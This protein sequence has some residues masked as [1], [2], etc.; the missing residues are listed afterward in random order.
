LGYHFQ[1]VRNRHAGFAG[2]CILSSRVDLMLQLEL[3]HDSD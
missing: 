1:Q 3:I 2:L